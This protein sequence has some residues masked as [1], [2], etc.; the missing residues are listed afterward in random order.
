MAISWAMKARHCILYDL[1]NEL[2][3]LFALTPLLALSVISLEI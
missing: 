3:A 1:A 2:L